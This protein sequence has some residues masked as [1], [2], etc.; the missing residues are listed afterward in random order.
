[1]L[2]SDRLDRVVQLVLGCMQ[3][4]FRLGAMPLHVVVVGGAG[5]V[6]LMNRFLDVVMDRVE[7]VP[8]M[9]SIGNRD[10]GDK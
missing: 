10:P 6:Q 7:I 3:M 4:L 8:V 9:N 1:M 5:V 2:C